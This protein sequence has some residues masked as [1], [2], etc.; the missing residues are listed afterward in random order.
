MMGVTLFSGVTF[1]R[2][3]SYVLK[4]VRKNKNIIAAEY[5]VIFR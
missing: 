2:G 1:S 3:I 5:L 4:N